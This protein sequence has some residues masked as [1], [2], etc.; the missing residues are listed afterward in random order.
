MAYRKK[1]PEERLSELEERKRQLDNQMKAERA[2]LA[3]QKRKDDDRRKLITGALALEHADKNPGSEFAREL[4]RLIQAYVKP[5]ARHLFDLP[6][7]EDQDKPS[8]ETASP[9]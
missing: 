1:S 3:R 2:K 9:A 5:D 6:P 8:A 7:L 4:N